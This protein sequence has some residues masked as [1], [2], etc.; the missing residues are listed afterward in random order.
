MRVEKPP[1]IPTLLFDGQCGFCRKWVD[2]LAESSNDVDTRPY[3]E[4]LTEFA[5]IPEEACERAVHWVDTD[6]SVCSGAD[7]AFRFWAT[8]SRLGKKPCWPES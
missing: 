6:G 5:Q 2:R 3:Q 4:A 1:E 8:S 7:A